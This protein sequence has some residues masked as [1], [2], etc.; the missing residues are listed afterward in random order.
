MLIN[1]PGYRKFQQFEIIT[2]ALAT[3]TKGQNPLLLVI[4]AIWDNIDFN[5]YRKFQ[6]F[7]IISILLATA[8][9][10]KILYCQNFKQF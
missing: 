3:A 9:I 4:S 2:I 6:Q 7:G 5:S 10:L 8:T 1:F